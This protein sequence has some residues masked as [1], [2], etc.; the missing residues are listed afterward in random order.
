MLLAGVAKQRELSGTL[1]SESEPR[2]K[3]RLSDAKS[4]ELSGHGIFARPREV[5]LRPL[6]AQ[7]LELN[8]KGL[9]R[10]TPRKSPPTVNIAQVSQSMLKFFGASTSFPLGFSS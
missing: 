8:D 1:L 3:K 10:T 5:P 4:R 6:A 2:L 7:Y 9:G